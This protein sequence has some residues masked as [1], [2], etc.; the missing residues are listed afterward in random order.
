M[1]RVPN[2]PLFTFIQLK[3]YFGKKTIRLYSF[4]HFST[5]IKIIS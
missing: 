4:K 5:I 3:L 2:I 1:S